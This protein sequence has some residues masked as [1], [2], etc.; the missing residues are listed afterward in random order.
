MQPRLDES[1]DERLEQLRALTDRRH[2]VVADRVQEQNR[3]EACKNAT[4]R[5]LI[6]QSIAHLKEQEK[7][8]NKAIQAFIKEDEELRLTR[9]RISNPCVESAR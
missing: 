7:Q 2:Q 4:V 6:D 3:R 5:D 8:L 9:M 1:I